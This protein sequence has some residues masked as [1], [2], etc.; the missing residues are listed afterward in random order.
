MILNN[1]ITLEQQNAMLAAINPNKILNDNKEKMANAIDESMANERASKEPIPLTTEG[2]FTDNELMV[3]TSVGIIKV[4]K[5]KAIDISIFKLTDSPFYKVIMGDVGDKN[6]INSIF[7]EEETIFALIYQFTHSA[8]EVY[9]LVKKSKE[10]YHNMVMETV[11]F[12]YEPSDIILLMSEIIKHIGLV[13][14]GKVE[15]S[16]SHDE[17]DKKKV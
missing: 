17:D 5:M 1:S 9:Q 7:P 15:L 13:N 3:N 2:I 10:E 4:R 12:I 6:S 14:Q 11:G 16:T 8:K